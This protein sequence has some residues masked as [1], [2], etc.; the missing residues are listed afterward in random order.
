[1]KIYLLIQILMILIR[2]VAFS[3]NP[4]FPRE[5]AIIKLT[6]GK[7]IK[8]L[9]LWRISNHQLEYEKDQ[10]LH[11]VSVDSIVRIET[12]EADY[13]ID[14]AMKLF[15]LPDDLIIMVNNDTIRCLIK[16]I[17]NNPTR[18]H[19]LDRKSKLTGSIFLASV[20]KYTWDEK[21]HE[22]SSKSQNDLTK[23]EAPNYQ[24]KEK[25]K[26][27]F[28]KVLFSLL[29]IEFIIGIAAAASGS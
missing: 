16:E 3:Q 29:L 15:Q 14:S 8:D 20:K 22:L 12:S 23:A 6:S 11:D 7:E 19:F 4:E 26:M 18:I 5:D 9:R 10:S 1:M 2:P 28:G 27:T 13:K 17:R 25:K 24:V 21:V